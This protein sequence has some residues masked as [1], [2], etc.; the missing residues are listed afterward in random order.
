M[1]QMIANGRNKESHTP[2]QNSNEYFARLSVWAHPRGLYISIG[3]KEYD[4]E[5]RGKDGQYSG[6]PDLFEFPILSFE[7]VILFAELSRVLRILYRGRGERLMRGDRGRAHDDV[8]VYGRG[9]RGEHCCGPAGHGGRKKREGSER[10][11]AGRDLPWDGCVM[12][13]K[14]ISLRAGQGHL[15]RP[16]PPLWPGHTFHI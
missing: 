6:K 11:K 4:E 7:L 5:G 1:R 13:S 12:T 3:D 15:I 10:E 2:F 16:P 8:S 14:L 9:R